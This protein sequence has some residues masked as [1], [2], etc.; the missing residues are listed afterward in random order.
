V[1]DE[2]RL[3][4]ESIVPAVDF[5][6]LRVV[7]ETSDQMTVRQDVLQ[8]V[9]SS[10]DRGAMVTVI[11]RGGYGYAATRVIPPKNKRI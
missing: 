8:P 11:H 2:I 4:F 9:T 7:D 3:L 6:S 10:I 5:C 1:L